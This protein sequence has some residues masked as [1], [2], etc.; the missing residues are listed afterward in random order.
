MIGLT[1]L[2]NTQPDTDPLSFH[3]PVYKLAFSLIL[4][5]IKCPQIW[6][7]QINTKG[8]PTIRL[9]IGL[10]GLLWSPFFWPFGLHLSSIRRG[11]VMELKDNWF[12]SGIHKISD[13]I[14]SQC[15]TCKPQQIFRRNQHAL[16]SLPRPTLPLAVLPNGLYRFASS[17]RLHGYIGCMVLVYVF[18]GWTGCYPT[19]CAD[20]TTM[21]RKLITEIFPCLACYRLNQIKELIW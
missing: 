18:S 6:K 9:Y 1:K 7:R 20:A 17:F 2:L 10:L 11:I 8:C 15:T 4:L 3:H 19:R 13:Q 16:G 5:I 12:C 14:I 21:V